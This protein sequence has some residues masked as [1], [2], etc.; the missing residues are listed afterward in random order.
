MCSWWHSFQSVLCSWWHSFQYV[1]C[2]HGDIPFS[3]FCV[4]GGIAFSLLC[5]HG[6]IAFS[7]LGVVSPVL[8]FPGYLLGV[9]AEALKD[10]LTGR[11]MDSQWGGKKE[12][13]QMKLNVEQA[14]YTR[15]A[16]AKALYSRL[17]D[18]LVQVRDVSRTS[19]H[20]MPTTLHMK[21]CIYKCTS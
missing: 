16:L 19:H 2:V 13:I 4:H 21:A 11:V 7:L 17:F 9:D 14:S 12:S 1:G 3:L 20:A 15:D 10:K 8:Q 6:G 18:W 5:L